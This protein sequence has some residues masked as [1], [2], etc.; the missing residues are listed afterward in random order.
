MAVFRIFLSNAFYGFSAW[1]CQGTRFPRFSLPNAKERLALKLDMT[2]RQLLTEMLLASNVPL[3][4]F[5][6]LLSIFV[7]IIIIII[8][9]IY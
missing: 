2:H 1:L 4:L 3:V 8:I 7:V 5:L 6:L 9:F